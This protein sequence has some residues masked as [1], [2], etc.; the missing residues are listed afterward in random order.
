MT[1]ITM[2]A[3]VLNKVTEYAINEFGAEN[4]IRVSDPTQHGM[5]YGETEEGNIVEVNINLN[6]GTLTYRFDDEVVKVETF[7]D[8]RDFE[9]AMTIATWDDLYSECIDYA[10]EKGLYTIGD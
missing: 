3:L 6:D 1:T 7:D 10:L 8:I 4:E 5:V 2:N 9:V